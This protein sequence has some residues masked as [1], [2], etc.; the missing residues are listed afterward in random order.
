M[1]IGIN[2][3]YLLP[4]IV[5]GTETYAV[6]MIRAMTE[7]EPEH[8]YFV[9][10]N[11]ESRHLDL[12]PST[13]I[14]RVVLPVRARRRAVRYFWEQVMLPG[15]LRELR[16]DVLHSPG[17]V[18]PAN[19]PCPHVLTVP[20]LNFVALREA[21][22]RSK[23][24]LL[25]FFVGTSVR[26][27]REILTLSESSRSQIISFFSLDPAKVTVTH[28]AGRDLPPGSADRGAVAGRYG[29]PSRYVVAFSSLSPHKNIP[30][31]I[32]AFAAIR[33]ELPHSLVLIGHI[34]PTLPLA[35]EIETLGLR[36]RVV[37]T[38]FVPQD[39]VLP[40]IAGAELYVLPSLYEGFGLP[41]LDAQGQSVAV[42]CSTFGSIP[43]VAGEG[44]V[45]FSPVSVPDIARVVRAVLLDDDLRA[46][47]IRRGHENVHRFSWSQTAS[48][49][50][51]AY[52]RAIAS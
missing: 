38:G 22:S 48:I 15:R 1:R 42:A 24:I 51:A 5:G 49:T 6:S 31:L 39:D 17:Y 47:L 30:R 4:G 45:Y 28:L 33:D 36:E 19:P 16:L 12:G 41:I 32:Q 46:D 23:R 11:E 26:G 44:A 37:L 3:L 40:L 18:G 35:R 43:E 20:D 29:L 14:T 13:R 8:D 34:P 27:A 10:L 2:L 52:K 7:L 21:M 9:I 25:R 50:L